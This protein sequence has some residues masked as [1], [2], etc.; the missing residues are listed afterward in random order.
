MTFY[1]VVTVGGSDTFPF[2][3][4]LNPF[5]KE[6]DDLEGATTPAKPTLVVPWQ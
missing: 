6:I 4:K 3:S 2:L 5:Y 1:D